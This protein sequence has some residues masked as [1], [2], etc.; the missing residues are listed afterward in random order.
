[1]WVFTYIVRPLRKVLLMPHN[2]EIWEKPVIIPTPELKLILF[3]NKFKIGILPNPR[4]LG[5]R[6]SIVQDTMLERSKHE[7]RSFEAR[8]SNVRL[9]RSNIR[10]WQK[11]S[12]EP[13]LNQ[14]TSK[15]IL[16]S[17]Q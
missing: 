12:F 3:S 16:S 11:L 7:E 9:G 1:M 8:G 4:T 15:Q 2:L 13:K 6:G 14:T 17:Q 10:S 5:T